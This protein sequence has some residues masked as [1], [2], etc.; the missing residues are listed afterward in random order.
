MLIFPTQ[1]VI[2]QEEVK[3]IGHT[4]HKDGSNRSSCDNNAVLHAIFL[5]H[6]F[7][8]SCEDLG[9]LGKLFGGLS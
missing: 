6:I 1:G 2:F 8:H 5:R 4:L 9:T 3:L 7:I